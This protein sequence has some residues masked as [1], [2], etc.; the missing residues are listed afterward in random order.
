MIKLLFSVIRQCHV[1]SI[2]P[3]NRRFGGGV[4]SELRD[5]CFWMSKWPE[6]EKTG[7]IFQGGYEEI[8]QPKQLKN[9]N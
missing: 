4:S 1:V 6:I 7:R 3:K 2:I 8:L 9:Q 5:L